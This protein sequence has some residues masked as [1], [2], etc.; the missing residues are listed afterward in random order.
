ML[1]LAKYLW[2]ELQLL[3]INIQYLALWSR[4][5]R[6]LS[7]V[8]V[9]INVSQNNYFS[10]IVLLPIGLNIDRSQTMIPGPSIFQ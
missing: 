6:G 4:F 10:L 9:L 7:Q 8:S 3:K 1:R 2:Y 5:Y